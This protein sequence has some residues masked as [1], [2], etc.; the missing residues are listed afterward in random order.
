MRWLTSATSRCIT[1]ETEASALSSRTATPRR[2]AIELNREIGA[3][4][5]ALVERER[6]VHQAA[7]AVVNAH[8]EQIAREL[9]TLHSRQRGLERQLEALSFY[10]PISD[11]AFLERL[12]RRLAKRA[13]IPVAQ[14]RKHVAAVAVS[15]PQR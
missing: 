12:A 14:A 8:A 4:K 6:A 15:A 5:R 2:T 11:H 10:L 9:V 7:I 1:R 13:A 3:A